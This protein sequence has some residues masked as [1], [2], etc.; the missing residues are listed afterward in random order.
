MN[1]SK[2]TSILLK[3]GRVYGITDDGYLAFFNDEINGWVA[4]GSN[5]I[6]NAKK[7]AEIKEES[8]MTPVIPERGAVV[9]KPARP[10]TKWE[11][12][13]YWLGGLLNWF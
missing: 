10:I 3:D 5:E 2:V 8:F 6:L 7:A 11:R 1:Q 13:K 9:V 12:F 4:R